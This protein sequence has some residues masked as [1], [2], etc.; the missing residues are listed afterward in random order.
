M[1]LARAELVSAVSNAGGL[2]I[3]SSLIFTTAD[4]MSREIRKTRRLTDKPFAVNVTILPSLRKTGREEFVQTAIEEGVGIIE[5]AGRNPESLMPLLKASNVKVI[6]K[7]ARVKDALNAAQAGVDAVTIVGFEAGGHPGMDDVGLMA[8]LPRAVD[9]LKIPV[10][11]GGGIADG[12]GLVAALAL[13]A[14][15]V[16]MGTRF[17]MSRECPLHPDIKQALLNAS[18]TDTILIE[19]SIRNAARVLKTD[20]SLKIREMEEKGV[21][22]EELAP[23][24]SGLREKKLMDDGNVNDGIIHCGQGVGLIHDIPSVREIIEGMMGEAGAITERLNKLSRT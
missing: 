14:E 5:T 24:I 2:G 19:R 23:F 20:F 13:G 18:E 10:I 16:V 7:V 6:H 22:R 17:M 8:L 11:A 3:M 1:W 12:R 9:A 21:T 15:G 4:E